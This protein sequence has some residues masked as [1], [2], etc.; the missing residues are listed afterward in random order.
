MQELFF[1]TRKNVCTQ[2]QVDESGD[3]R[4]STCISFANS[5]A[6]H[7]VN[8][9]HT[10]AIK[11]AIAILENEGIIIQKKTFLQLEIEGKI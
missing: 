1:E 8:I 5:S 9:H 3:Y 2:L 4:I 11:I 6:I 7:A 10:E